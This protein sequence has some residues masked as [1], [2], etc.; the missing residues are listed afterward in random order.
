MCLYL[1]PCQKRKVI[2]DAEKTHPAGLRPVL[3]VEIGVK[4]HCV[5]DLVHCAHPFA[6]GSHLVFFLRHM[7][8]A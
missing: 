4:W 6:V 5:R 2:N 3:L 8:Q 1:Y 7:S